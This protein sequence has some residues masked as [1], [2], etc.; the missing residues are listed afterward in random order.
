MSIKSYNPPGI[1]KP[2]GAFSMVV[3]QGSGQVLHLKG[4]VS[5]N[6]DGEVIGE[7]DI[8]LQVE[9]TLKNIQSVLESFGGRMEDVYS[10]THHVTDIDAFMTTG[11]IRNKFFS[12]PFPITTTVEVSKLYHT[13]LM[14][15]ITT[16]AEI[17]L[18]RFIEPL[19]NESS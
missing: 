18:D 6:C 7:G 14:V 8:K 5:L 11:H 10:L 16:S 19:G 1:W 3:A 13:A 4:Q 2:F 15:E 12:E 9:T 17:P